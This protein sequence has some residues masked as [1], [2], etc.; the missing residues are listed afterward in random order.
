MSHTAD[1]AQSREH[2]AFLERLARLAET[3]GA[4]GEFVELW[5]ALRDFAYQSVPCI[6]IFISLYDSA[7]DVRTAVYAY[8]DDV[9]VDVSS[10]PPMPVSAEGPNS[11][12]VLTRRV[13]ITNDYWQTKLQ[14]KGQVGILVGP[15]NGLRPQSSLVV[16]MMTMGRVVGTVEVQ[17]YENEAYRPEHVTAMRMAANLAA[18]AVEN[19]RLLERER[20]ARAEAEELNRLKDEFLATLSHELRTPLTAILGWAGMLR[21]ERL[22]EAAVAHALEIIERNAHT[23]KQIV[24]DILDVSRIITG[25]LRLDLQPTELSSVVRTAVDAVRPTAVAKQIALDTSFESHAMTVLADADRFQQ[26]VWNLLTN[27]VKFTPAGGRIR[28]S[29][30]VGDHTVRV[31]VEDTGIGIAPDFLPHVFDRFRQADGSTTRVFSGIGLG[32][33]IVR[34][35]VE[36]H[37]GSVRAESPGLERGA[38]FTVEL[39]LAEFPIAERGARIGDN[40]SD[41]RSQSAIRNPQSAIL[42]GVSVLVVDDDRDTLELIETILTRAGA[43]VSTAADTATAVNAF[44]TRRPDVLLSDIGMPGEDGYALIRKVRELEA[45]GGVGAS[46]P[47]AALTAYAGRPDRERVLKAGYQTHLPKPIDPTELVEAV[48]GLARSVKAD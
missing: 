38:T 30:G 18:V 2:D 19:M 42:R 3:L 1:P 25:K 29:V 11:R 14:G 22:D 26:V 23:Q 47:A 48:V 34:H 40:E 6:G 32:L 4:A 17:S 46:T 43:E 44:R 7:R 12:A 33:A 35:L 20:G 15:D 28:L 39:P 5:R 31:C 9:E 36:L 37:G 13:V 27:A 45:S 24:D 21:S 41:E 16:P 10:L 8:G